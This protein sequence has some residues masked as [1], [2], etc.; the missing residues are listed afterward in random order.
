MTLHPGGVIRIL[1]GAILILSAVVDGTAASPATPG[2]S[3]SANAA[4]PDSPVGE[5]LEWVLAQFD[6]GAQHLSE[7][8]IVA[9][10]TPAFLEQVPAADAVAF[11]QQFAAAA[12]PVVYQAGAATDRA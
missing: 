6:D 10:F 11:A 2:A 12:A 4:F 9:R 8:D 1:L 7:V 3:P 5:Q